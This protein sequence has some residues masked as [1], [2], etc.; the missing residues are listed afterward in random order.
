MPQNKQPEATPSADDLRPDQRSVIADAAEI[1]AKLARHE[2]FM[3]SDAFK[4][5]GRTEQR[6][7]V[8]Q[9]NAMRFYCRVLTARIAAFQRPAADAAPPRET[10]P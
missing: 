3:A 7:L 8:A 4:E 9:R 5:E 1:T 2:A 10:R 6:L